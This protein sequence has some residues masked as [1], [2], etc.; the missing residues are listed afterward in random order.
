MVIE[1]K[2]KWVDFLLI[3]IKVIIL[4]DIFKYFYI[5]LYFIGRY[6]NRCV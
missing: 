3:S 5:Y 2:G 6:K 1:K 4:D